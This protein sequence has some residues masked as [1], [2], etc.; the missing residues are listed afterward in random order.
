MSKIFS[1]ANWRRWLT[2][3]FII[4]GLAIIIV[5]SLRTYRSFR[6]M[7]FVQAQGLEDGTANL[8]AIR[9]WMTIGYIAVAYAVP[10]EYIYAELEIPFERR[11]RRDTLR[12]LNRQYDLGQES[13][14]E[15][16][17]IIGDVQ[18]AITTYRANPVVVGLDNIREWMTIRYIAVSTGV[19]ESHIFTEIGIPLVDNNEFKELRRLAREYRYGGRDELE[20]AIETALASYEATP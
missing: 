9:P 17:K 10:E 6:Q 15:S 16:L 8:D 4:G 5:Y 14:S 13:E 12:Q 20:E 11:N 18:A 1:P 3:V 19:P 7:R 2:A